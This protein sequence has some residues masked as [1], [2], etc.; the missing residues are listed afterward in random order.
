MPARETFGFGLARSLD[1]HTSV[2]CFTELCELLSQATGQVFYPHHALSY[3]ELAAGL[4]RGDLG[5]AW[6][7]PITAIDLLERAQATLLVTPVRKGSTLY[8]SALVVRPGGPKSLEE[9]RGKRAGWVDRDSAAGY[10]VPRLHLASKGLDPDGFFAQDLFLG[11]HVAVI[12]AVLSGRIDVGAT[13]AKIEPGTG[14]ILHAA[15][16]T[17]DGKARSPVEVLMTIGPIP[18]DVIVASNRLPQDVR[19]RIFRWF[20][21]PGSA[22]A[23]HLLQELIRADSCRAPTPSH[24]EPLRRMISSAGARGDSWRKSVRPPPPV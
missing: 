15:W 23:S 1:F 6:A 9:L 10:I 14:R 21:E 3:G 22:R 7:P 12:E 19:Q 13:F 17:P 18:S 5:M 20:I 2:T 8:H 16:T 24:Y 4:E 11:S